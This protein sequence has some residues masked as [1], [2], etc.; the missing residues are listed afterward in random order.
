MFECNVACTASR[1][2]QESSVVHFET[3]F[4]RRVEASQTDPGGLSIAA[5]VTRLVAKPFETGGGFCENHALAN[6]NEPSV[7]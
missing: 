6:Q 1:D 7:G 3:G 5:D 2:A 4:Y